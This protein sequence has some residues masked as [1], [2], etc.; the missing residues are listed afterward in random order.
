MNILSVKKF[1]LGFYYDFFCLLPIK[2]SNRFVWVNRNVDWSISIYQG[3]HFLGL[4][5]IQTIKNPAIS[6]R[7]VTD[8]YTEFVADPFVVKH[9]D[10]WLM[11]FE[12]LNLKTN[13]GEISFARSQDGLSWDYQQIVLVE[14]FHLSYPQVFEF[15]SNW[16]MIPETCETNSV[17]LYKAANFPQGWELVSEILVG[18]RF[19]DA[20]ILRFEGVWWLFAGVEPPNGKTCDTLKLYYADDL[21]GEWVEH[22]MS[23]VVSNNTVISRPAGRI[24]QI[25]DR[26]IRFAQDCTTNYGYNV[27]A[28]QIESLTKDLY[29]ET[30]IQHNRDYIFELGTMPFNQVGMHH[31]DFIRSE[32][33]NYLAVV[34]GR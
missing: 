7:D 28:I 31:L 6:R 20:S 21:L 5:P 3:N 33:T 27:I 13:R 11:F 34:D 10:E 19:V 2:L 25:D 1:F 8:A 29:A 26:L 23:P 4:K 24:R 14:N 17:R 22:P 15:E 9:Q 16:Y 12:I 30:R 32:D 18:D